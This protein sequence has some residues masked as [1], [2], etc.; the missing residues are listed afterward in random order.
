MATDATA[1]A[2]PESACVEG[3]ARNIAG[4][5]ESSA[6]RN[7][8]QKEKRTTSTDSCPADC[9]PVTLWRVP[10]QG[11]KR[12]QRNATTSVAA[13]TPGINQPGING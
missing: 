2:D 4:T 10:P 11:E 13:L 5:T 9:H 7:A 12:R 8:C 1:P 3:R 6:E